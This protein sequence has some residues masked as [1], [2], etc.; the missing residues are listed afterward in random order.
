MTFEQAQAEFDRLKTEL[1]AHYRGRR[2]VVTSDFNGQPFGI[3]RRSLQ[4][5][6]LRICS[7]S[8]DSDLGIRVFINGY[9]LSLGIDELRVLEET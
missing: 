2:A 5:Q 9:T 1:N 7:V 4:G 6:E 3:S 8:L